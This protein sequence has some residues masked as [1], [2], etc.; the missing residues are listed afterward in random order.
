MQGPL[1]IR[2]PINRFGIIPSE[3]YSE[4][5]W[6][7]P[8]QSGTKITSIKFYKGSAGVGSATIWLTDSDEEVG[9]ASRKF[10]IHSISSTMQ[11]DGAVTEVFFDDLVIEN[12]N[13]LIV[14][15]NTPLVQVTVLGGKLG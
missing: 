9:V 2:E 3:G 7:F 15:S 6:D 11:G 1:F 14:L 12:G 13:R 10:V 8:S 4:V 5:H